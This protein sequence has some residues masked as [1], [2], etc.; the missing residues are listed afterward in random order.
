MEKELNVY[1]ERAY[2]IAHLARI[3]PSHWTYDDSAS[4]WPVAVIDTPEGQLSWHISLD[5][6]ALFP[7]MDYILDL[8][9]GHSTEEKYA[10]LSR[11]G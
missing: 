6:V 11:L 7:A 3:Y 2:L 5:D 1:R 9:D 8:W 10:R 4:H